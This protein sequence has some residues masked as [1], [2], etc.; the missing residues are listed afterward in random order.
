MPAAPD[1]SPC[2]YIANGRLSNGDDVT[3]GNIT[4]IG[5]RNN[6]YGSCLGLLK[7]YAYNAKLKDKDY[8]IF[9]I[10][11]QQELSGVNLANQND[12]VLGKLFGYIFNG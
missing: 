11:E 3:I 8:S 1:A 7:Y 12:S 4:E 9:T 5:V 2:T 6:K 10:D